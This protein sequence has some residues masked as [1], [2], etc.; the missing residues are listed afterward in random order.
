MIGVI[1]CGLAVGCIYTWFL[2]K[3]IRIKMPAGVPAG[4][5]CPAHRSFPS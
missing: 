3:D 4:V 5:A 1:L 2:E